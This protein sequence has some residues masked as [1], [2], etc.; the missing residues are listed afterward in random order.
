[1]ETR[2]WDASEWIYVGEGG[3]HAVFSYQSSDGPTTRWIGQLLRIDKTILAAAAAITLDDAEI[4]KEKVASKDGFGK[5]VHSHLSPYIDLPERVVLNWKFVALLRNGA[6]QGGTVPRRRR[7][8]WTIQDCASAKNA[9]SAVTSSLS[10]PIGYLLYDYRIRMST[11]VAGSHPQSMLSLEI[12]PKAGYTAVSPL[13]PPSRIRKFATSRFALLQTLY[14][15]G[16]IVK[17]WMN[18]TVSQATA[19][20]PLDLFS[21][22]SD[23][24]RTALEHL[25]V[26][27]QNNFKLWMGGR[28]ILGTSLGSSSDWSGV[29]D[30]LCRNCSSDV[31]A[32]ECQ[33]LLLNIVTAILVE[34]SFLAQLGELQ[35]VDIMDA[36][37]AIE[38]YRRLVHHCQGDCGQAE[39]LIDTM[40]FCSESVSENPL[41]NFWN[42]NPL[43]R[44]VPAPN[45]ESLVSEID[46]FGALLQRLKPCLPNATVLNGAR[47]RALDVIGRLSPEE[48]CYLLQTW[49]LSLTM[50]DLSFFVT[51]CPSNLDDQDTKFR[52]A[53]NDSISHVVSRQQSDQPGRIAYRFGT[54]VGALDYEIKVIDVDRKPA[55]KLRSRHEK[56]AH[57]DVAE[58]DST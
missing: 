13:V 23:R 44:P 46:T 14:V 32:A 3:R 50:S 26:C 42:E 37:G 27:P 20:N 12:K 17:D 9:R 24:I 56:E 19:Y 5:M 52:C 30:V 2:R 15:E 29:R 6:L 10:P 38:I 54:N 48:C 7:H 25:V 43:S 11:T 51:L 55:R 1:M 8:D 36:D 57:F 35:K 31:S 16:K 41:P 28:L 40:H 58:V 53:A 18:E 39:R 34:E 33:T 49:L 47:H 45:L 22:D 21:Q 4:S